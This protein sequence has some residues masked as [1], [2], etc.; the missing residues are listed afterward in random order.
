M[1]FKG[2]TEYGGRNGVMQLAEDG[3]V[4]SGAEQAMLVRSEG[5]RGAGMDV[6]IPADDL[7][8]EAVD[9]YLED[10]ATRFN[11]YTEEDAT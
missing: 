1:V 4:L 2:E 5:I 3:H 11:G 7:H 6:S 9:A 8:R 10:R